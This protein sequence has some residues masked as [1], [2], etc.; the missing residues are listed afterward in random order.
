MGTSVDH[1]RVSEW[2]ASLDNDLERYIDILESETDGLK[3]RDE[4]KKII[5]SATIATA[6]T[7]VEWGLMSAA[8]NAKMPLAPGT[9]WWIMG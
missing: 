9:Y 8:E 1:N 7:A 3:S 4:W 6:T 2:S 5:S